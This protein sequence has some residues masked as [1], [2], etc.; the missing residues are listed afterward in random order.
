MNFANLQRM[1]TNSKTMITVKFSTI[2]FVA[3]LLTVFT[4][5]ACAAVN[6]DAT[7]FDEAK[8]YAANATAANTGTSTGTDV[9]ADTGNNNAETKND[10]GA[11]SDPRAVNDEDKGMQILLCLEDRGAKMYGAST[12]GHCSNQKKSLGAKAEAEFGKVYVE[13]NPYAENSQVFD[14]IEQKIEAYPTWIFGDGTRQIGFTNPGKLQELSGCT[15]DILD[16][17]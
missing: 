3:A 1:K 5:S 11:M 9:G 16:Q 17:Y 8:S 15:D 6:S 7:E 14:C 12:C 13:C 2:F 4:F 10:T